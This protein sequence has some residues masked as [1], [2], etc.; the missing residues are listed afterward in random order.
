MQMSCLLFSLVCLFLSAGGL[1]AGPASSSPSAS[2]S[3]DAEPTCGHTPRDSE[4]G[5][6][7]IAPE[8]YLHFPI[9]SF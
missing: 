3:G 6:V 1:L 7:P 9:G 5:R 4:Q 8:M 2:L